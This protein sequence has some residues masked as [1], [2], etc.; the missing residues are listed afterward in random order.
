MNFWPSKPSGPPDMS[1]N[2]T[3]A[4]LT[5]ALQ[6]GWGVGGWREAVGSGLKSRR[7]LVADA[8]GPLPALYSQAASAGLV[9]VH[10]AGCSRGVHMGGEGQRQGEVSG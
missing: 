9:A 4:L 8:L 3:E 6:A 10:P 2:T 5:C 1:V 7:S